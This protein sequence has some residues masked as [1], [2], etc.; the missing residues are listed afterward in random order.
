MIIPGI[1]RY[2]KK[3]YTLAPKPKQNGSQ[4]KFP[5]KFMSYSYVDAPT[6]DNEGTV[7]MQSV[8]E[9][10]YMNGTEPDEPTYDVIRTE[11]KYGLENLSK[12]EN[13][14]TYGNVVEERKYH[15]EG[16]DRRV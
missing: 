3:T 16:K 5:V 15:K 13:K 1:A 8:V 2:T 14:L 10:G 7:K 11:F 9:S 12:I 6:I 4:E